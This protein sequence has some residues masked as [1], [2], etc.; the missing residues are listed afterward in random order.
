MDIRDIPLL[1]FA[2]GLIVLWLAA[3]AG[4]YLRKRRRNV[5]VAELQDLGLVLT[6]ALT[7]LG[8]TI[9]FTFS[10]AVSRYDLRKTY[11]A[12]EANAIGTEYVRADL[13]PAGDAAKVR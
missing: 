12:E 4:A 8:L 7:L 13:L 9:G 3:K 2:L 5:D 1:V 10:M 11:E 6:A